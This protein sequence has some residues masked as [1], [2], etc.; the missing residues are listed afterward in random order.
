MDTMLREQDFT[1][2]YVDNILI[3][4]KTREEHERYVNEVFQK[5]KSLDFSWVLKN[6][7]LFLPKSCI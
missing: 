3:K 6:A 2:A 4:S 5:N 1:V 7:N